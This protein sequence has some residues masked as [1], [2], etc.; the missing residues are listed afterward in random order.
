MATSVIMPKEGLTM[1]E[2]TISKWLKKDGEMV[3]KGQPLLEIMTDKVSLEVEAPASGV[4]QIIVPEQE[5]VPITT[6]IAVIAE[7]GEE[8]NLVPNLQEGSSDAKEALKT[9]PVVETVKSIPHDIK[10]KRVFG[11][12]RARRMAKEMGVELR[13][14]KG[15]G[16]G[17]RIQA[18]DVESLVTG[19]QDRSFGG[20]EAAAQ[21]FE[22]IPFQGIRK[23]IAERL[24][25]CV[26]NIPQVTFFCEVDATQLIDMRASLID[27]VEKETGIRLTL[28]DLLI[29]ILARAIK[30]VPHA[31]SIVEDAQIKVFNRVNVSLAVAADGVLYTPV[32]KDVEA[33]ELN[34][35]AARRARIVKDAREGALTLEDLSG[36]TV[37]LSNLGQSGV[38]GFTPILNPPQTVIVGIGA[39]KKKPVIERD[40][41][42]ISHVMT[43][44]LTCDH[45]VLDGADATRVLDALAKFIQKPY[46]L[47]F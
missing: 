16:F 45:R 34:E 13:N 26:R 32:I 31:N 36:G 30:T 39:A 11:S 14:I 38:E 23:T 8:V 35:I 43:L 7:E 10:E 1:E 19:D 5:T 33:L 44:S 27:A 15:T 29:R 37:T 22:I 17:G 47:M 6:V 41:I 25:D 3:E 4:L 46:L 42:K 21:G 9:E 2:G 12:P 18:K 24:T 28:T 40:Q 20:I